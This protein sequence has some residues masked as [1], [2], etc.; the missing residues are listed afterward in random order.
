MRLHRL[1]RRVKNRA[2]FYD[3]RIPPEVNSSGDW[4]S[5]GNPDEFFS[6]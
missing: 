3:Y 4:L 6:K 5:S 2:E 1:S